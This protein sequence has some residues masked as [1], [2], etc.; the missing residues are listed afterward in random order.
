M[1]YGGLLNIISVKKKSN[2]PNEIAEIGNF[3]FFHYMSM[4]IISYHSNQR[5]YQV[6]HVFSSATFELDTQML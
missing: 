2:I 4:E 3:H 6:L 1:N 5:S